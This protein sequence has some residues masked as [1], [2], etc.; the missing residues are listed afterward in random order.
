MKLKTSSP[1]QKALLDQQQHC[2]LRSPL[3]LRQIHPGN[4]LLH[5]C[6]PNHT[7]Y[8]SAVS[9]QVNH[10]SM[11]CLIILAKISHA[12]QALCNES[13]AFRMTL[14]SLF[15]RVSSQ[16]VIVIVIVIVNGVERVSNCGNASTILDTTLV[17]GISEED[18]NKQDV[19]AKDSGRKV[20]DDERDLR[21]V[22]FFFSLSL[23]IGIKTIWFHSL[24]LFSSQDFTYI[25]NVHALTIQNW[26][27]RDCDQKVPDGAASKVSA[28]V[29][30][31]SSFASSFS[32]SEAVNV[33]GVEESSKLSFFS[34]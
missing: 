17:D 30:S 14:I 19:K 11:P 2:R 27:G 31:I 13:C 24:V 16:I 12:A 22:V 3:L 32:F 1:R 9:V 4:A 5:I 33:S 20:V 23:S 10:C 34:L 26:R 25:Y 7:C 21:F 6:P 8:L 15:E 28:V 18:F 29:A